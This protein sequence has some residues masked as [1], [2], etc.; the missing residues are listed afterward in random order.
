MNVVWWSGVDMTFV[1]Q[2]RRILSWPSHSSEPS[3]FKCELR[4]AVGSAGLEV[5]PHPTS[6]IDLAGTVRDHTSMD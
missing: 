3:Q 2:A 6:R 1:E 4:P 5:E